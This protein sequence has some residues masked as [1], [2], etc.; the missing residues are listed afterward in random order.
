MARIFRSLTRFTRSEIGKLFSQA[1]RTLNS[2]YFT[3][4]LSPKS[5][6]HS[7]VL[8]VLSRKT[9]NAPERNLARRRI[10]ASFYEEKLYTKEFDAI[11]IGRKGIASLSCNQ[12]RAALCK[13]YG[14]TPSS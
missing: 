6:D 3:I 12:L 10:K 9:G 13:V 5:G 2:P 1:R 4:L 7:R 14:I 8:I 11:F